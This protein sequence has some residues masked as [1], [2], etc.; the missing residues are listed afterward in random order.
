[1]PASDPNREFTSADELRAHYK[2]VRARLDAVREPPP[3]PGPRIVL[4]RDEDVADRLK[5]AEQNRRA[6]EAETLFLRCKDELS[7]TMRGAMKRPPVVALIRQFAAEHGVAYEALVGPVR[8]QPLVG[9]RQE[10]MARVKDAY[11]NISLPEL[12]RRFGGRDHTTVLHA[13]RQVA[14][15]RAAV[16][17]A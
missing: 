9:L 8:T 5:Q 17:G 4:V 12:G 16:G 14:K 15:R 3:K 2:A 10:C 13:L 6:A 1:M 11:P 7:A